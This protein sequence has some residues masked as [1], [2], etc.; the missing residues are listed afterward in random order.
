MIIFFSP[1]VLLREWISVNVARVDSWWGWQAVEGKLRRKEGRG[2]KWKTKFRN[3]VRLIVEGLLCRFAAVSVS[4]VSG[5]PSDM[6]LEILINK[7]MNL[8]LLGDLEADAEDSSLK[9]TLHWR[10]FPEPQNLWPPAWV[11]DWRGWAFILESLW[12]LG[13]SCHNVVSM[14]KGRGR[15][16]LG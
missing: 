8:Y 9:G 15:W 7:P 12:A 11:W 4:W 13:D 10:C 5:Q 6:T 14:Q 3:H 2:H 16:C 1:R